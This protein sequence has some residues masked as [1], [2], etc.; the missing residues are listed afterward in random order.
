M[1]G[2]NFS[3]SFSNMLTLN[4]GTDILFEKLRPEI[5]SWIWKTPFTLYALSPFLNI[6]SG[7]LQFDALII[8]LTYCLVISQTL[9]E[10]K[11]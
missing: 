6:F 8:G 1:E 3:C 5:R 11:F 7:Y 2:F 4:W 9:A 10:G